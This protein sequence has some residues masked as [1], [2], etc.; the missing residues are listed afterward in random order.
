MKKILT[1]VVAPF[2]LS[3]AGQVECAAGTYQQRLIENYPILKGRMGEVDVVL[4]PDVL[5]SEEIFIIPVIFHVVFKTQKERLTKAQLQSQIDILNRDFNG[6]NVDAAATPSCFQGRR[7]KNCNIRFKLD[8]FYH[9]KT[10]RDSFVVDLIRARL[11]AADDPIKFSEQGGADAKGPT[12]NLNIWTGNIFELYME[13]KL[14]LQGYS[15]F[16]GIIDSRFDGVVLNYQNVGSLGTKAPRHMGR[17]GTHE[18]GHWLDL[19]HPWGDRKADVC[20]D[21]GL[22]DT[23]AQQGPNRK[24]PTFPKLGCGSDT[25]GLLFMNCMD[26][27]NDECRVM[28]TE[29]QKLRMRQT[30][31][32]RRTDFR[33]IPSL[34]QLSSMWPKAVWKT[35]RGV[36]EER[37]I[38]RDEAVIQK[39]EWQRGKV[40]VTWN[41]IPFATEYRVLYRSLTAAAWHEVTTGETAVE[42]QTVAEKNF[43]EIKL[44]TFF[45][46]EREETAPYLFLTGKD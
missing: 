9:V 27:T 14:S 32:K 31:L 20:G 21:D 3:A 5:T 19:Q 28:F 25:N 15:S 17:V 23:P 29:K 18:V 39:V 7:A 44:V 38:P 30:L 26:Y 4:S 35:N 33:Y 34:I 46:D 1:F 6:Q 43:Y 40:K 13:T 41:A 24:C 10:D 12:H 11:A 2:Y 16:P 22:D 45:E 42:I 37:L 36:P 8:T